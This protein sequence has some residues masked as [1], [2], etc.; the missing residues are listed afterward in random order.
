M[1]NVEIE[2]FC[3]GRLSDGRGRRTVARFGYTESNPACAGASTKVSTSNLHGGA[4]MRVRDTAEW[5]S[6]GRTP[7]RID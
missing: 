1:F 6:L 7:R 2:V 3:H 4:V 5:G